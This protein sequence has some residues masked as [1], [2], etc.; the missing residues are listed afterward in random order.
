[1]GGYGQS[2]FPWRCHPAAHYFKYVQWREGNHRCLFEFH[3]LK[4]EFMH[5]LFGVT[6]RH[7]LPWMHQ[8]LAFWWRT[9]TRLEL[10]PISFADFDQEHFK[11]NCPS[12]SYLTPV[13]KPPFQERTLMILGLS[14]WGCVW[15]WNGVWCLCVC[16]ASCFIPIAAAYTIFFSISQGILQLVVWN[17]W[18]LDGWTTTNPWWVLEC[19]HS[20]YH[21]C[22]IVL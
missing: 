16:V 15:I 19:Q 9:T 21:S 18:T 10:L 17:F 11:Q 8:R 14:S 13:S 22:D 7:L 20:C 5:V 3:G 6:L 2:P 1:M 4:E 12:V